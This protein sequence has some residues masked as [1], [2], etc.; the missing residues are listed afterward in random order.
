MNLHTLAGTFDSDFRG[1]VSIM[2]VN[3]GDESVEI[4]KGMRVAQMILIPVIKAEIKE[5][6]SLSESKRGKK[7]FV[8][9]GLKKL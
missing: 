3:M 9:L 8:L 6:K 4:E 1:E 7:V 2:L 5:V